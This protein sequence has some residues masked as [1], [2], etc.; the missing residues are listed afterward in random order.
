MIEELKKTKENREE[1][2]EELFTDYQEM[3]KLYPQHPYTDLGK[4]LING[5]NTIKPGGKYV[6]FIAPDLNG[7]LINITDKIRGK[8]C[9]DRLMGFGV[10]L[11]GQKQRR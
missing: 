7:N 11:A 10:Y 5:L 3:A 2:G 1:L 8:I 9:L 4:T 6:E